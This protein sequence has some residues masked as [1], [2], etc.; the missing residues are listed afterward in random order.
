MSDGAIVDDVPL[1]PGSLLH[2]GCGRTGLPLRADT[3]TDLVPLGGDP[4]E[5]LPALGPSARAAEAAWTGAL[6]R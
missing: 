6:S 4:F 2:L 5:G 1:V 3:A